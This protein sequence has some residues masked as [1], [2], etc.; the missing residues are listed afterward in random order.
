MGQALRGAK[1]IPFG[2]S[3]RP[4]LDVE[5]LKGEALKTYLQSKLRELEEQI[6]ALS[7]LCGTKLGS[8]TVERADSAPTAG[9][10]WEL[11]L[12]LD[13]LYATRDAI[14]SALST[15]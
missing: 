13:Y 7:E 15:L 2:L 11:L 5:R 14:I 1:S 3:K 10:H 9:N 4:A 8:D 6:A 12:D